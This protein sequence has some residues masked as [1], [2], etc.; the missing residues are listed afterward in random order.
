MRTHFGHYNIQSGY[1]LDMED[2]GNFGVNAFQQF[3]FTHSQ[4]I[5]GSIKLSCG[6]NG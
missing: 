4:P 6:M 5:V 2:K 1:H 3:I